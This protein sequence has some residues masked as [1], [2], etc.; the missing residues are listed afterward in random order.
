MDK[1]N[2][3]DENKASME[4]IVLGPELVENGT[5]LII[6]TENMESVPRRIRFWW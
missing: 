2:E 1:K 6:V 4:G 5:K 3:K